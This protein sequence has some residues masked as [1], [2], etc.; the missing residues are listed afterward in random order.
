MSGE[1]T[2]RLRSF[3]G[4]LPESFRRE[5]LESDLW[6]RSH[7]RSGFLQLWTG[8]RTSF[9]SDRSHPERGFLVASATEGERTIGLTIAERRDD[10]LP[11]AISK[12]TRN[13]RK[14]LSE[15]PWKLRIVARISCFVVPERR[16]AGIAETMLRRLEPVLVAETAA[17]LRALP[18]PL[19]EEAEK[20]V[21]CVVAEGLAH[22]LVSDKAAV[23]RSLPSE[24]DGTLRAQTIS[25]I[26]RE[27]KWIRLGDEAPLIRPLAEWSDFI[28]KNRNEKHNPKTTKEKEN[29]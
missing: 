9:R 21:L 2:I 7:A 25:A 23:L 17:T 16:R 27:T 15:E 26:A 29:P 13:G 1:N 3:S 5:A 12:E 18:S 11:A 8:E 24:R 14:I 22:E 20:D 28:A 19:R 4:A 6:E 10:V